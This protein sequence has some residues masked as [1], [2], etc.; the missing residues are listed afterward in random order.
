MF[1]VVNE[2]IDLSFKTG[3]SSVIC[4]LDIVKGIQPCQLGLLINVNR[5]GK[6]NTFLKEEGLL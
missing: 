3:S 1:L 4:K 6:D 2:G 5:C